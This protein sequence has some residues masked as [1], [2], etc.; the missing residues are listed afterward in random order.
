MYELEIFALIAVSAVFAYMSRSAINEIMR[1]IYTFGTLFSIVALIYVAIAAAYQY[2]LPTGVLA[3]SV[4]IVLVA[5]IFEVLL[6][7]IDVFMPALLL[8]VRNRL[9]SLTGRR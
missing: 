9:G 2:S 3:A 6:T 5:V 4:W 7:V 8:P 1:I